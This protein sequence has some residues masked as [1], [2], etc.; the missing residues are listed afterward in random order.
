M[1][2]DKIQ[3]WDNIVG[4]AADNY[5]SMKL[6]KD[7]IVVSLGFDLSEKSNVPNWD[8]L[9]CVFCEKEPTLAQNR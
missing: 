4:I 7:G 2:K 6:K 1:G 9:V 5:H 3:N 8:N